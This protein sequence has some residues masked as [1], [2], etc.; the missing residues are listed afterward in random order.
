MKGRDMMVERYA[1]FFGLDPDSSPVAA[2]QLALA[3][4]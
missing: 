2:K 1:S 3:K 4:R